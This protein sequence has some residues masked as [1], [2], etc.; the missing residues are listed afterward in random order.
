MLVDEPSEVVV[1][2]LAGDTSTVIEVSVDKSDI[3]K[4]IGKRGK[5][6]DAI[7][8]LLYAMAANDRRRVTLQIN[9]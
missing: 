9:E 4:V 3:G 8:I 2:E 7:R 1:K 5:N 6:A